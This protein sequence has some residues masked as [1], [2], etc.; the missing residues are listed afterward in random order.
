MPAATKSRSRIR[1]SP[2]G[3]VNSGVS[4]GSVGTCNGR[5]DC[6][7]GPENRPGCVPAV[8]GVSGRIE[9]PA[10][11]WRL[12]ARPLPCRQAIAEDR[13]QD[14]PEAVSSILRR[15]FSSAAF[16]HQ[17]GRVGVEHHL[18]HGERSQFALA[19]PGQHQR[20]V[21]QGP[22]PPEPFQPAAGFLPA[23][24]GNR[25]AFSLAPAYTVIASNSGRRRATSSSR[26]SSSSVSA[27]RCRR[28]STSS[29]AFGTLANG[30]ISKPAGFDAPVAKGHGSGPVGVAGPR[31]HAGLL[32]RRQASVPR[33]RGDRSPSR[34]NR[35]S[36]ASRCKPAPDV[37]PVNGRSPFGF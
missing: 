9:R 6:P 17:I 10:Q 31:P 19:K 28:G 12:P 37:R 16:E 24:L 4:A 14:R 3:T 25:F 8:S 23:Q 15:F 21:D 30:L 20:L 11:L 5:Q 29:S 1:T 18:P 7:S 36:A 35:Q 13:R 34:L 27:R 22:F 32:L 26:R 33:L 2:A